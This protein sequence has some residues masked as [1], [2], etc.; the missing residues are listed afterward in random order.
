MESI[1]MPDAWFLN[2]LGMTI[3]ITALYTLLNSAL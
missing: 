1:F 2:R 3:D